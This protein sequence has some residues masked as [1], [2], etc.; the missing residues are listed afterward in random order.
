MPQVHAPVASVHD[1]II[2]V[3]NDTTRVA[4]ETLSRSVQVIV[5]SPAIHWWTSP[6]LQTMLGGTL[7]VAGGM[8]MQWQQRRTE[9]KRDLRALIAQLKLMLEGTQAVGISLP[10]SD[11]RYA[12]AVGVARELLAIWE[13]FDQLAPRMEL[14]EAEGI[15]RELFSFCLSV[16]LI[17]RSLMEGEA[18][19][20]RVNSEMEHGT[21]RTIKRWH[22]E[23][24]SLAMKRRDIRREGPK[25]AARAGKLGVALIEIEKTI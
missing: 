18:R 21:D 15:R 3:A 12:T 22:G 7:A 5:P 8:Y 17:C 25:L 11:P 4:A 14:I 2:R 19:F 9:R 1:T 20:D 13:P 6:L 16:R 10:E 24:R 23:A